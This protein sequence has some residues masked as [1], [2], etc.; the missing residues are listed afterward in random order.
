M[1][2][3]YQSVPRFYLERVTIAALCNETMNLHWEDELTEM[4]YIAQLLPLDTLLENGAEYLLARNEQGE[5]L[6]IRY[7]LIRNFPTPVK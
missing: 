5:I 1:T 7:D 4:H 3:P 6:K 2:K